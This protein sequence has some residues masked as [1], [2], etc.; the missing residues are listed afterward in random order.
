M[1]RTAM[2]QA[3][4]NLLDNAVKFSPG[5]REIDVIAEK[6]RTSLFLRVQDYGQGISKDDIGRIF[7]KFYQGK[8]G[9]KCS[10]R[11]TGLGLTLVKHTVEA[12][13]GSVSVESKEGKG[14]TFS[15][16][17]PTDYQKT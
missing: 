10:G 6:D 4:R 17:L 9:A 15:L 14:S 12:H 5:N 7:E 13:G 1:D 16:M 2:A 11:G 8:E 3:I